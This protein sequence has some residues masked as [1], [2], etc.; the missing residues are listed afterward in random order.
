VSLF[1]PGTCSRKC[2]QTHNFPGGY[3]VRNQMT[4]SWISILWIPIFFSC[5][6]LLT[7]VEHIWNRSHL[8]VCVVRKCLFAVALLVRSSCSH[9]HH[10]CMCSV[11]ELLLLLLPLL[12][13]ECFFFSIICH[14]LWKLILCAVIVR[15]WGCYCCYCLDNIYV[16]V[17]TLHVLFTCC[18]LY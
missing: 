17:K 12:V 5:D 18:M 10:S 16:C 15:L 2:E 6:L 14:P 7:G 1:S 8:I 3:T 13:P 11:F 9:F 4:L